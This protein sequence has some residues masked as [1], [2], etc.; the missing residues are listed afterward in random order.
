MLLN[1]AYQSLKLRFLRSDFFRKVVETFLTQFFLLGLNFLSAVFIS[2]ALGPTLRGIY[3]VAM[4]ISTIGIQF[5]NL[6]LH[7][8]NTYYVAKDPKLLPAIAGNT[9]ATTLVLGSL[10]SVAGWFFCISETGA[11]RID[12]SLL[13]LTVFWIPLGLAYMLFQNILLGIHEVRAFNKSELFNRIFNFVIVLSIILCG[14]RKVSIIFFVNYLSISLSLLYIFYKIKNRLHE[15]PRV[16]LSLL[17]NSLSYAMRVYIGCFIAFFVIRCDILFVKH[18][19]GFEQT[20]YYSVAAN[21]IDILSMFPMTIGTLLFPKLSAITDE[22]AKL[23]LLKK[24]GLFVFLI[25]LTLSIILFFVAE[26]LINLV[27]GPAF[28]PVV[29]IFCWLLPGMV[30]ISIDRICSTY[31]GSIGAPLI[32][33]FSPLI[34]LIVKIAINHYFVSTMGVIA[35]AISSTVGYA[36]M[37]LMSLSY[38]RLRKEGLIESRT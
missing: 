26:P 3:A 5:G 2:R 33:I 34:A 35:I 15:K 30:F 25:M 22:Q 38:I 24:I 20:G 14:V 10:C 1:N 8:S 11:E 17:K 23:R 6:G 12:G 29:S 36:L 18:Y 4:T 27:Y 21:A 13:Y 7:S 16:S 28:L 31:F 9:M 32:T 19:L 37:L